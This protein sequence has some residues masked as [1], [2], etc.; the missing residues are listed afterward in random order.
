MWLDWA[1]AVLQMYGAP[2]FMLM[3]SGAYFVA[4]DHSVELLDR[5]V[6]S[7]HGLSAALLNLGAMAVWMSGN[8]RP[9]F[10]APFMFLHLIPVALI[11]FSL[12]RFKGKKLVHLLQIPN[13]L[14][15]MWSLFVGSM[16]VTGT[17]L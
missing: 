11:L 15:L 12:V 7:S 9:S 13:S 14:F 2:I 3:I 10:A 16:A 1:N 8:A 6:W 17:W 4:T 5:V